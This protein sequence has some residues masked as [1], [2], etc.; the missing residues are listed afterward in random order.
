[1]QWP[2]EAW[3][4]DFVFAGHD[5]HYERLSIDGIVYTVNGLGGRSIY[6]LD[7]PLPGQVIAYNGDYGAQRLTI[8]GGQATLA[9]FNVNGVEIDSV[10]I[11]KTCP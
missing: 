7:S 11:N 5:H 4:M 2:Y 9:F 8:T 3:G 10:T 1:M 6:S